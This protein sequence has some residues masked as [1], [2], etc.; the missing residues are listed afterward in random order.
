MVASFQ[1]DIPAGIDLPGH[2]RGGLRFADYGEHISRIHDRIHR[3]LGDH[4]GG[5]IDVAVGDDGHDGGMGNSRSPT[6]SDAGL[7]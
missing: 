1:D 5:P 4:D 7:R 2:H 6:T 3:H